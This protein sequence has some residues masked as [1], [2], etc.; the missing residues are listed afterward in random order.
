M[1]LTTPNPTTDLAQH[2]KTHLTLKDGFGYQ[3]GKMG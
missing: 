2:K 1:A 3:Q